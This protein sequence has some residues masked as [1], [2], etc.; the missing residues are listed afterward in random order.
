MQSG[1]I[2]KKGVFRNVLLLFVCGIVFLPYFSQAGSVN[3]PGFHAPVVPKITPMQQ[4]G[5]QSVPIPGFYGP[6]VVP[7]SRTQLPVLKQPSVSIPGISGLEHNP[8]Q[9]QLIIHQN[10]PQAIIDWSSFDIGADA[11]THFDQQGNASWTALNRIWNNRPSLIFGKLTADGKVFLINQNGI[12]FGPGSKVNVH[13]LV[14][15]ALTISDDNFFKNIFIKKNKVLIFEQEEG[16]DALAIVS[17]HGEITSAGGGSLFLI[18]PRVENYGLINAPTGNVA[19]V[20]GSKVTL[21]QPDV[22]DISRSG[23]YVFI[24]DD[25]SGSG[26]DVPSF[27][28]AVNREGGRLYADGGMAGMYGNT[29]D[30][31]GVIRSTTAFKNNQGHVELRAA[32]KVTTGENSIISLPVDTSIDPETGKTATVSD[33]FDIQPVVNIKGLH[34]WS[35]TDTIIDIA[36]VKQI[37]HRGVIEAPAGNLTLYADERVYLETGSLIDVSGVIAELPAS[38]IENFKLN[39]VELRDAYGQK[40]G[41]LQGEQITTSVLAGSAIGDLSQLILTRDRTALERSIGGARR[42]RVDE[43]T[44]VVTYDNPQTGWINISAADGDVIAKQGSALDFAGGSIRYTSGFADMTK[45]LSGTKIYDISNA[46]LSVQYDKIMSQHTKTYEKFGV[47]EKYSGL[48]YGGASPLKTYVDSYA[49][50]GDAGKLSLSA[51]RIVLDGKLNG[52]VTSGVFQN[53]WTMQGFFTGESAGSDYDI[54][55]ALSVHRGLEAPRCGTL[56]IGDKQ[57]QTDINKYTTEISVLPDTKPRTNLLSDTPLQEDITT[58]SAEVLNAANLGTLSLNA[59]LTISTAQDASIRLQPGGSFEARGRRIHYE[60][61]II[62][63]GGSIRL[64]AGQNLTSE[65]NSFGQDNLPENIVSLQEKIVLGPQS[66]LDVSGER[67]DNSLARINGIAS[68]GFSHTMGGSIAI[69]DATDL[70]QGVLIETGAVVDVSGG[71]IIDEHGKVSGGHAGLLDIQGSNIVLDGDLR[72]YALGDKNGRILG[73]SVSLRSADIR[74]APKAFTETGTFVLAGDRFKDTGFTQIILSSF[75]DT[76]IEPHTTIDTSLVRLRNPVSPMQQEVADGDY[77][78]GSPVPGQPDLIRLDDSMAFRAGPSFFTAVAGNDFEGAGPDFTGNLKQVDTNS[79]AKILLSRGAVIRTAPSVSAVTRIANDV[80]SNPAPVKTGITLKGPDVEVQ[81]TLE[82][83]GGNILID[84]KNDNL[85]VT[86]DARIVAKGY[87]R[88]DPA[89]TPRNFATNYLPVSGGTVTLSAY[90]DLTLAEGSLIDIS[91]SD[92]V[93]NRSRSSEGET[94]T[95]REAGDPGSLSLSFGNNL[96]W[97]GTVNAKNSTTYVDGIRGSA[98][99]VRKTQS[100]QTGSGLEI[101]A[102]DIRQYTNTG[103]DDITL[104][105][106]SSVQFIGAIDSFAGTIGR[107]LTIDATEISGSANNVILNAPWIVLTNR[108]AP[109]SV[110]GEAPGGALTLSGEWIDVIGSTQF[111]G[112]KDVTLKAARDIRLSE[113]LYDDVTSGRLAATGNLTI[114][115]DRVYT[116]GFYSYKGGSNSI[117]TGVYSDFI[118]LADKKVVIQHTDEFGDAMDR[119]SSAAIYATG[120]TLTVEGKDGIEVKKGGFLAAPMGTIKLSSPG[121]RIYLADGSVLSTAAAKDIA[122]N[123]GLIDDSNI[124]LTGD[125]VSIQNAIP[126]NADSLPRKGVTLDADTNILMEGAVIDVSGGGSLFAYKFLPGIEGSKD[127]LGKAGRYIVFKNNSFEMPGSAVYLKGG[128]GLSE[129]MYTLLPLDANHPENAQYAF[130]FGAYIIE[131]QTGSVF[132]MSGQQTFS[133]DGYPLTVGYTAVADTSILGT[134]PKIYSVRTAADVMTEGLYIKPD[135]LVSGNAGGIDIKG[136]SA[137]INGVFRAAAL[138][139]YEGGSINLSGKNISI[140]AAAVQL[141][142]GFG[143]ST[144]LPDSLRDS[145]S[146]TA[147]GLSGQGFLK[148]DLGDPTVTE[149]VSI[150]EDTVLEAPVISLNAKQMITIESGAELHGKGQ[151]GTGEINLNAP[152]G[153]AVV[154]SG[155][156]VHTSHALN[157]NVGNPDIQGDLKMDNSA[158]TLKAEEIYFGDLNDIQTDQNGLHITDSLWDRVK[159]CEDI[160]LISGSDLWFTDDF[161]LSVDGK[162]SIDA[163][164]IAGV[165]AAAVSLKAPSIQLSNS[166][167][168]SSAAGMKNDGQITLRGDNIAVGGG[169]ILFAGFSAVHL[170]SSS[171]VTLQG[172]GSIRTGA[173]DLNITAARVTTAGIPGNGKNTGVKSTPITAANFSVD[174]GTGAIIIDSS[175]G[176]QGAS[177]VPGGLLDMNAR[178]IEIA[179]VMQ[180]DAGTIKLTTKGVPDKDDDGIFLRQEGGRILA[181]GTDNAPGGK[182]IL[183]TDYSD[184][185]GNQRSGAINLEGGSLID[186]SAGEQGNAGVL[187]LRGPVNGVTIDG[188]IL[189]AA[190]NGGAGGSFV[191]DTTVIGD[192]TALNNKLIPKKGENG[193]VISGGFAEALDIKARNGNIDVPSGQKLTANRIKLTADSG[194]INVYQDGTIDA[195]ASPDAGIVELYAHNDLNIEGRVLAKGTTKGEEDVVLSSSS[196]SVNLHAAGLIDVSGRRTGQGAV[197]LR[198]LQQNGND[199]QIHLDG[200]IEGASAVYVESVRVYDDIA[201]IDAEQI[202]AW[203]TDTQAYMENAAAIKNRLL[204]GTGLSGDQ[205]H[206]LPGIEARNSTGDIT[207][208]TDWDVSARDE[209]TQQYIWRYG[210][211]YNTSY[212]NEGNVT[213]AVIAEPGEP[214]VLTLRAAGNIT[215]NNNLADHPTDRNDLVKSG[216]RDSWAFNLAAGAEVTG[217]DPLAVTK[218]KGDLLIADSVLV[219]TESG[220]IRFASGNDTVIGSGVSSGYMINSDMKYSLASYD[221][222]VEGYAGRDLKIIGG[223][224]QTATGDIGITVGRDLQLNALKEDRLNFFGAIRT[225]GQ[226][227]AITRD[228]NNLEVPDLTQYW[229]Y[230]GGG[231]ITLEVGRYIGTLDST[232]KW[233]TALDPAAWDSFTKQTVTLPPQA[234]QSRPTNIYYGLFSANYEQSYTTFATPTT[235]LATMGGGNLS[236]RTGGDFLSQAGT[237]GPGDLAIYSGGNIKGRFL[238]MN[239]H[240]ELHAMGNIGSADER[241]QIELFD[242]RMNVTALG[243]IQT[244]AVLNPTL[245]SNKND[246]YKYSLQDPFMNCTYSKGTSIS[247]KAGT[248]VTIA[249]ESPFYNN[250]A[251]RSI[252]ETILPATVNVEAGGDISLLNYFTLTSSPVGNLRLIAGGDVRGAAPITG[253]DRTHMIMISDIA[254]EYWYG[255]FQIY[256]FDESWIADRTVN[257]TVVSNKHGFYKDADKQAN[258]RPIHAVLQDDTEDVKALKNKPVEIRAGKDIKNIKMYFSKKAEVTAKGDIVNITYEGQN[259]NPNDVSKIRSGGDILMAYVRETSSTDLNQSEGLIQGGPGVFLVQAGGSMDLGTLRDGVQAIGNGRYAQ[260]GTE[261]STLLMVSGY[262]FDQDKTADEIASFFTAIRTAGDEYAQLLADG[263]GDEGEQ[264]LQETRDQVIKPFL[265]SPSG[266]GDINM[267][268]SQIG[269]SIGKSDIYIIANRYLNLGQTALPISGTISK[270][271]GITTGGGGSINIYANRDV[272]VNESRVM[273]FYGGDITVWS[274]AGNINAGRG[275]RTAVSASPPKVMDDGT[276]VFSPPAIGSG[277]R[278]VTFGDNAP[279]PGDIHLFAP[280]GIIDAGEAEISGGR[281]VLAAQQVLN[282]QNISFATGSVGVPI[283]TEGTSG[284]GTLSGSG[285]VAAQ[286]SQLM[287]DASGIA[288]TSSAQAAKMI[289]DIMTKWLDVKVIEFSEETMDENKEE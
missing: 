85:M 228:G 128:G 8:S 39:S 167:S 30:Q 159:S 163:A 205:V 182:V 82:S 49:K 224:I 131:A 100:G 183:A 60:G 80:V 281:I 142:A 214:G 47:R 102:G 149:R 188:I 244:G 151:D 135:P 161:D 43:T 83:L 153:A 93:E 134:R 56:E 76:V 79:A 38:V 286:S 220:P 287:S 126:F 158:I 116:A 197:H 213:G 40:G 70:G 184:T 87:N 19:L 267:T 240:G 111:S 164:R 255:L 256:G 112:F 44:G 229:T 226:T 53:T 34:E 12:L 73:G 110:S 27:G 192:I 174:A 279:E 5:A 137:I 10:Q 179:S 54:A 101:S 94:F 289:D 218:G 124:W 145:L 104:K 230:G 227:T 275:S 77:A 283:T 2:M 65:K 276:K 140:V 45:I 208:N 107:K 265:G 173:A 99:T 98:L 22:N 203:Q 278:A 68:S 252:T 211:A 212:D 36:P 217:A 7:P 141:P 74:V 269:T 204:S 51:R 127:P 17:N 35:S 251:S 270:T 234:G 69:K 72:G 194:E 201:T 84:V 168:A 29:V 284:I 280:T 189:G 249:G 91:G 162:L 6:S 180:V 50:G 144:P 241:Q 186:V 89:S 171:D 106:F 33:T 206:V 3:V 71:Y 66:R 282:V 210:A 221:G 21:A 266:D 114:D 90:S 14:A 155:A 123:Y 247:L 200:A 199:V 32:H 57:N 259:N 16:S 277:I 246:A 257:D 185:L 108:T 156:L 75:N 154:E 148:I 109:V 215:I 105:S 37:E 86:Q 146:V 23:Y 130:M 28:N 198:A 236:V 25:F 274:D 136:E 59:G 258:A 176:A 261:K 196:G 160:T 48:Y 202:T 132:P 63:P 1:D 64:I 271:T 169:D 178:R 26:S 273:T 237:F 207:L 272:N 31:W 191:L 118:V 42:T 129:G 133:K 58:L 216:L 81:G 120:G 18:A 46:P 20:A 260:L 238:T 62:V 253:D 245:A 55:M 193:K 181:R 223:A 209:T 170:K 166:G 285:T 172:S 152:A 95:F 67:I 219:Y 150:K 195:S 239:G 250:D 121:S 254:P 52:G 233:L 138:D 4:P 117:H 103:F 122:V 231:D 11:S 262:T 9:N 190:G 78:A 288:S 113:V 24:Y 119:H 243:E 147:S 177:S 242:S 92:A 187:S 165:N 88:P 61:E 41:V 235:G 268:A 222:S 248:D 225:T 175:G 15:S 232:K 115:A 263:K 96:T 264:L 125:K 139:G 157:L 13:S 97:S 143:F